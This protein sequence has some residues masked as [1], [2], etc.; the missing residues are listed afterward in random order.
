MT[1]IFKK[2]Y[3]SSIFLLYYVFLLFLVNYIYILLFLVNYLYIFTHNSNLLCVN[4]NLTNKW[5]MFY[6]KKSHSV[7]SSTVR[8]SPWFVE[9]VYVN[10]KTSKVCC[11][12]TGDKRH[13]CSSLLIQSLSP[14]KQSSPNHLSN[15]N[16][17]LSLFFACSPF[18]LP[19]NKTKAKGVWY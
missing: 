18:F 17:L 4:N 12:K 7:T 19:N 3:W 15:A 14:P 16:D 10:R 6:Q 2:F 13:C 1:C 8:N 9:R 5:F 11:K